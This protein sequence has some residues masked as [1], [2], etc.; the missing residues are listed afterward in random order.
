MKWRQII[1]DTEKKAVEAVSE[2]L[3]DC[4][5]AGVIIEDPEIIRQGIAEN[6]WDAYEF[7]DELVHR[8]FV[9][10]KAYF[11]HDKYLF[12]RSEELEGRL[13]NLNTVFMEKSLKNLAWA[14]VREEDWA[15][16]WKAYYKPVR[17]GEKI[18]IKPTWEEYDPGPADIII[19]LDPGMAFG[20][21]THPTTVMCIRLL[22]KTI[23][24]GET[25]FDIGT[26]SGILAVSA[27]KLGAET[28]LAV[29]L[30]EV[31]VAAARVN[32]ETNRVAGTVKVAS[33]NLLDNISGQADIIVA[34]I[35]AD[36]IIRVCPEAFA[37]LKP[38]GRFIASGIISPR[39]DAV[40]KVIEGQG[41]IIYETVREG[42]WV[43][44]LAAR[45]E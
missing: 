12:E 20:T 16:S 3:V 32:V 17:A 7:P 13:S 37:A 45:E 25:V 31:A 30:D 14:D 33:G 24:G 39:S 10:V 28:V 9:R 36:I 22:E 19:E 6:I 23:R 4:G 8:E 18:I 15:N 2:I 34:N 43:S 38:G 27:A 44:F 5:A 41:F 40:S 42:D 1:V 21:G 29:D 11:P 35:V 26:G